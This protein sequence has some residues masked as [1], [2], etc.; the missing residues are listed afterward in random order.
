MDNFNRTNT[1]NMN[2]LTRKDV[3][4]LRI[5][6]LMVSE[7]LTFIN[8]IQEFQLRLRIRFTE[9]YTLDEVE[10][11]LNELEEQFIEE[12]DIIDIPEDFELK[13]I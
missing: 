8:P 12:P 7:K 3:L 4:K 6:V 9:N 1:V 2:C 13:E 10:T 5:S 11:G